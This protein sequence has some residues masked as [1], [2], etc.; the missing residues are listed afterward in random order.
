VVTRKIK[1]S[2]KIVVKICCFI[3]HVTTSRNVLKMFYAKIFA[4]VLQMF[5]FTCNH[6]LIH[7]V[8]GPGHAGLEGNE[9]ANRAAKDESLRNQQLHLDYDCSFLY[10]KIR[11]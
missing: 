9:K 6:G 8:W 2:Q 3:L 5:Y 1:H 4:N 11:N 7:L 10:T